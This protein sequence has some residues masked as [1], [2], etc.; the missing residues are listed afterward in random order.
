V[1]NYKASDGEEFFLEFV[2]Q[3]YQ[4]LGYLRL[5][6]PSYV[7]KNESFFIKDLEGCALIRELHVLGFATPLSKKGKV[8]HQGLGKK[9]IFEAIK[10]AKKFNL[11][12]IAVISAVGTRDYYRNLGFKKI[13]KEEY[14]VKN[15]S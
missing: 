6:I 9:L 13:T 1:I 14:L 4:L 15:I 8:Q 7:L 12:K 3:D 11:S 10:I 2:D 5:R